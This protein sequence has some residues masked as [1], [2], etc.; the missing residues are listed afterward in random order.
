[1]PYCVAYG[2]DN[3]TD[4][5]PHEVSFHRLPLKKPRS[6]KAGEWRVYCRVM[7]C[8]IITSSNSG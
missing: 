8:E 5:A 1:M 4:D 7:K 3:D 2:C 6:T